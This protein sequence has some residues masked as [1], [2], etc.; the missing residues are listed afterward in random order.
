MADLSG[1]GDDDVLPERTG[2]GPEAEEPGDGPEAQMA[3]LSGRVLGDYVLRA[4]IGGG[5][6]G[7]VYRAEHLKLRR[8]AVVK[9]LNEQR[10]WAYH[11][12]AARF[13]REAQLASQLS[14]DNAARVYEFGVAVID[15]GTDDEEE[16]MWIAME[17]VNGI[18]FAKW[19]KAHG[20]MSVAEVVRF[21]LPLL[22]AVGAAHKCEIVH[23]DLKPSNVMV[24]EIDGVPFPKLIDFGIAKGIVASIAEDEPVE[25]PGDKMATDLIRATRSPLYHRTNTAPGLPA[26]VPEH[27][28]KITRS[29]GG[30]GSRAY[31][32]PEQRR[33]ASTVGPAADIYSL[34]VMLCEALTGRLPFKADD[35]DTDGDFQ[36]DLHA[37][38]DILPAALERVLYR[39]L[40]TDPE[41]RHASARELGDAL[42]EVLKSDPNEQIGLLA[43]RWDERGRPK[44][45]LA[46]GPT[47]MELRRSVQ[48]PRV[49]AKLSKLDDSFITLSLQRA[50]RAKWE[51]AALIALIAM[52]GFLVRAEGQRRTAYQAATDSE[53][54]RGQQALL[55]GELSEAV[56]HLEQ[57]YQRGERSPG[58][59]F[60]LARALQPRTSELGRL[61]SSSGRM[62]SAVFSAD[63]KQILTAD[64]KSAQVWDAG[65]HQ[66]LFTMSHGDTVYQ[67]MFSPGGSK[68]LTSGADGTVRLWN[69][70]TG[71]PLRVMTSQR[72]D[73][74][75]WRYYAAAMS[76]HFVAAIDTMGRAVHVWDEETGAQIAELET[77]ASEAASLTLSS[78]GRWLAAS[79]GDDVRVFDTSTWKRV[80]AIAGP[81]VRSL[82]F[83]STGLRLVV[84]TYDGNASIW[85]VPSGV[86]VRCLRE[87]GDPVDAV[88]FSHDDKLVA[89]GSR[90]G[91]EQVW[92]ASSGGL[93]T[94]FNSHHSKIYAVEFS[95]T[96]SLLLSAGA[97][98]AAVVSNVATGMPVARL[99]GPKGFVFTAHFDPE[100]R[101][102]VGASSDGT[103][104]VWDAAS[105]YR[106]WS[107]P[108]I[109]AEC[110]TME[111]L[112]PDRRFVALSCRNRGTHIWDTMRGELMAELPTVTAVEGDYYSAFPA[113]TALGDRAAIARGNTV[114]VYA[115][116]SGHLLRVVTHSAAVNAVAFAPTGHDLVSGAV[117]GSLLITRDDLDP[118]SLPTSAS[119]IDAV[120]ILANGR[121]VMADA[122]ARLRV[123]DPDHNTLLMD[124]VA[125]FR[126]RLL[127]A[128]SDG[129]RL[130]TISV[131]R[132][133]AAPVL[134][135]L[136]QHRLV[137]QLDGHGGRVFGARFVAAGTMIL[138]AGVDGTARL[139]DAVAGSPRQIFHGDAHFLVDA[140]LAPDGS[141]VVAGGSDG[142]LRFWDVS[143]GRLLWTLQAHRS[144]V[145]GVHYEGDAL[146]TRGFAGDVSRWTLPQPDSVID[147]CHARSC[148]AAVSTGK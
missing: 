33:N 47:L 105:M 103:A 73:A 120:A 113:V 133:Q 111:S 24:V 18:D 65:S 100:A 41:Q 2:D 135:D 20:P 16:L 106:S 94:Q 121:V 44:D 11:E 141:M 87:A 68:I 122:S 19:L 56:A 29:G 67:A 132:K 42:Q 117:D 80:V 72:S 10:R 21:F 99:E 115:L 79:G 55:H 134:W 60:M 50:R 52:G 57:A 51:L 85:E 119:G 12:A 86:R 46:R 34:G 78:D 63:G 131:R 101:R 25:H 9:V 91:A 64:D 116:P 81:R 74:K 39:T 1:L 71:A 114:E 145:V 61:T 88:A 40:S 127:R 109:G 38:P 58:V 126:V 146:V 15:E 143:G 75:Q 70:D 90:D 84:G 22:G 37:E 14:H 8:V 128:S 4:R 123:I 59:K 142:V 139:W 92:D 28:R 30:F 23:R 148:A 138:T 104:R 112:D 124:L 45:L 130:V 77:D 43:R 7:D 62:W 82:A 13:R 66:L 17:F 5:G 83:D 27:R 3:D 96:N 32:S 102:V 53:V 98:G 89:T 36:V 110:D 107:S 35:T 125:P 49:A 97:D 93:R 136:A 48:S 147:A 144:Y 95:S 31:M 26:Y 54:E 137:A 108:P 118:I 69:A 76:S 140:A 129:T 6:N